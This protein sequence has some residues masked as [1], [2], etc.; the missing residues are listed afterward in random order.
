VLELVVAKN[1][2]IRRPRI[3]NPN[4]HSEPTSF[5]LLHHADNSL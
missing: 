5:K 1:V 2:A 3:I 4:K